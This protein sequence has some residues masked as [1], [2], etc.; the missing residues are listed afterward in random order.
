[1][2]SRY[3]D[4]RQGSLRL[5]ENYSGCAFSKEGTPSERSPLP[6]PA[7][8]HEPPV[9]KKPPA[10]PP[11]V[12]SVPT[13]ENACD[14]SEEAPSAPPQELPSQQTYLPVR[15][16]EKKLLSRLLGELDFD[17]LLI[18]GL[19]LL[20]LHNGEDSEMILWL[21]LLLFI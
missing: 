1:M 6:P 21:L 8:S 19:I 9:T 7:L 14:S 18:P 3:Y 13:A 10:D 5:P 4:N 16:G 12:I 11:P 2:Y 15:D 20:L 17:Q